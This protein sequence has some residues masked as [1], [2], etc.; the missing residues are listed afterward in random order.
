MVSLIMIL[1][2]I[3][4]RI[5]ESVRPVLLH[6][7]LPSRD[8]APRRPDKGANLRTRVRILQRGGPRLVGKDSDRQHRHRPHCRAGG[9]VLPGAAILPGPDQGAVR[10]EPRLATAEILRPV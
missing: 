9:A 2:V 10:G 7:R 5:K 6:A 4:S 1:P 3:T 8:C